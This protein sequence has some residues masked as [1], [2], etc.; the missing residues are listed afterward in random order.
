MVVAGP[1]RAGKSTLLNAIRANSGWQNMIY[2]G[3]HRSM[4]R[5]FVQQRHLI[6]QPFVFEELL[7][8]L[9]SPGFEGIALI[10]GTRDPWSLDDSSNYLKHTLCQIEVDFQQAI[11]ERY[12]KDGEIKRG[13]LPDPWKPLRELCAN[14]LPHM[15]FAKIDS[16][17]R[18][19]IRCLWTVHG[20]SE[21][22]DLD[23]LSSGEKSIIQMFFPLVERNIRAI[24]ADVSGAVQPGQ[25]P[26]QC[27]L[28]DEPE[29][30]L[31]P[32]LQVKVL[33]YFRVLTTG[34]QTQVII[35]TQ[36]TTIVESASFEEL[37]LLRPVELV[38]PDGNQLTQIAS[39]D[40][41]LRALRELFGTTAN[42]TSMQPLIVVEG[43]K[44]KQSR[45]V[46]VDRKLYR[47]L[48]PGFDHITLLP[49]GGKSECKSLVKAL[50]DA[51]RSFT[52]HLKAVALID[53]DYD[54]AADGADKE[55]FLLPVTMI[56]NFLLDPDAIWEA[57]QSVVERAGF[58]SVDDVASALSS[59]I[60]AIQE[61][62]IERRT[63]EALG[64]AFFRPDRPLQKVPEKLKDFIKELEKRFSEAS[65][66]A[67][68]Q[69]ATDK[70]KV[71]GQ[72]ERRREEFHGKEVLRRFY[73]KYLQSTP[74]SKVVF[75]FEAARYARRRKAVRA[76]FDNFFREVNPAW[77]VPA[78]RKQPGADLPAN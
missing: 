11:T 38:E 67:G 42:L 18:N 2:L 14:L 45:R 35:A 36:S 60:D 56:E 40:D 44:E 34:T 12:Y 51:L 65:I 57:I 13:S 21:P 64:T 69:A 59:I 3:P 4:R 68:L 5:Q 43:V 17:N 75:S 52:P 15:R 32:N 30:H 63:A 77:E 47:A 53:R 6:S 26:E 33:D 19:Q 31:H 16:S 62:E 27:V 58:L 10:S 72:K 37:F 20:S 9:D 7:T 73:G 50:R 78:D 41:R 48:H 39:D 29:L 49:A 23:D 61:E 76:F 66:A 70:V 22:V 24:L 55:V 71:I 28:I 25:R 1:N 8:R 54:G 74:I 46:T